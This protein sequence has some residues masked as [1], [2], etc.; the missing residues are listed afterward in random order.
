MRN[1]LCS[2]LVSAVVLLL[3][4]TACGA[5]GA[6]QQNAG[7]GIINNENTVIGVMTQEYIGDNIAEILAIH[8]DGGQ[9]ALAGF[10]CKNPEAESLNL[11]VRS[12]I[13]QLYYD[14]MAN[15]RDGE[16]IEIRS[17][18]FTSER[19]L[20]IV[21][22][23]AVYP[24]YGTDGDM[25]SYNFD[26]QDN[27]FMNLEEVLSE[28]NL[29]ERR[30][31]RQVKTLYVPEVPSLSVGEVKATGF[32]IIQGPSGPVTQLLLTVVLENSAGEPWKRFF[33][34]T[35]ALNELISLNSQCLFDPYDMDQMNPPLAY[36][37]APAH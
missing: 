31:T 7:S 3:T 28:L 4:A 19:Y 22:T 8:Y 30:L 15:S 5:A 13:Q 37:Q 33:A 36:Q 17:Y 34:Y 1:L 24:A 23:A 35:P 32:L 21:T 6:R 11:T 14:F 12:G 16:W 27:R 2:L 29:N 10:G 26:K 18:P 9:P 20:Q 25:W